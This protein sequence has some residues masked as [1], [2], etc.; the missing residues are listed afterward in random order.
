M[1]RAWGC[2]RHLRSSFHAEQV[3]VSIVIKGCRDKTKLNCL[4]ISELKP[5]HLLIGKTSVS[6][7]PDESRYLG[8]LQQAGKTEPLFDAGGR[9]D[10]STYG[11]P[12]RMHVVRG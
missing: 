4:P 11:C 5:E 6:N 9:S 8:S 12:K 2:F 10:S 3:A 7:Q 1:D